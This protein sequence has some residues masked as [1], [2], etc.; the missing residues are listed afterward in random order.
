MVIP[1]RRL[2][3]DERNIWIAVYH[4]RN[5][6]N[7]FELQV[8]SL[9]NNVREDAG[10]DPLYFNADLMM[11]ARFKSQSMYDLGYFGSNSPV[12]GSFH[13]MM[14]EV[15]GID[16]IRGSGIILRWYPTPQ[17]VMDSMM[18]WPAD[19]ERILDPDFTDIGIGSVIADHRGSFSN[20]WTI[21]FAETEEGIQNPQEIPQSQLTIP[22]RRPTSDELNQWIAEYHA[23]GGVNAFELEVLR[24]TNLERT[25]RGLAPLT[26][27]PAIAM[28]ARYKSQSMTDLRYFDHVN[29]V[30][31]EFTNMS[32]EL[33]GVQIVSENLAL[34]QRTPQEVVNGWMNSPGHR[35]NILNPRFT[36]IGVGFHRFRWTQKFGTGQTGID[37]DN[38]DTQ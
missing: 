31:G 34:W 1:N 7:A 17:A 25:N 37:N 22:D 38:D 21:I 26:L 36:E 16:P 30:F 14:L 33:F 11:A 35:D 20:F 12:Y 2:T 28:A 18:N 3:T 10:L 23:M 9:V 19:V 32:R 24:L 13:N 15:F 5:G 4:A 27:N 29:P 8:L 6:A